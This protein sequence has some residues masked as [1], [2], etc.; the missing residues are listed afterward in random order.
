MS[1]HL[2]AVRLRL[3][4]PILPPRDLEDAAF[5][6]IKR[7]ERVIAAARA[8]AERGHQDTCGV[9]L[10]EGH[11]GY[12]CSCGHD[13]LVAALAAVDGAADT[14]AAAAL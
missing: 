4:V 12:P 1:D 11:V 6:E 10:D 13:E 7:V 9:S 8:R 2:D 3:S 14:T 5:R